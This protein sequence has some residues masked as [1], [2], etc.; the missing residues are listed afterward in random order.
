MKLATA[1][2]TIISLKLFQAEAYLEEEV[3]ASYGWPELR[4]GNKVIIEAYGALDWGK[5]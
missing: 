5:H 4:L 1:V 2:A 3:V